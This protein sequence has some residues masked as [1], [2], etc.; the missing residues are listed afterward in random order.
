MKGV[1]CECQSAQKVY[2]NAWFQQYLMDE[3]FVLNTNISCKGIDTVP[4]TLI[5]ENAKKENIFIR[6]GKA[7]WFTL[8]DVD[9]KY[10]RSHKE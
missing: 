3:H 8:I 7:I 4:A 9:G 6:I 2:F 1:C 10:K 5:D